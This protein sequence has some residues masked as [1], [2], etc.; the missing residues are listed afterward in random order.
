MPLPSTIAAKRIAPRAI[1]TAQ[2]PIAMGHYG[3]I[4]TPNAENASLAAIQRIAHE[5]TLKEQR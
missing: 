5:W 4:R 2:L 3:S 1:L